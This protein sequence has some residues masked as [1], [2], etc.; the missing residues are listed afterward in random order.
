MEPHEKLANA[1]VLQAVKDFRAA[2]RKLRRKPQNEDAKRMIKDCER[3][4]LSDWFVELTDVDGRAVLRK[5]YEEEKADDTK[6]ISKAGIS[7]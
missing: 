2:R 4:F 1:I 3:F 7:S 6:R 5:L